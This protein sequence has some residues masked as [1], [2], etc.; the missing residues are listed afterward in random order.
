M[1]GLSTTDIGLDT[2]SLLPAVLAYSVHPDNGAPVSIAIE[3]HYSD[4]RTVS[5]VQIPF[6]IQR[7]VNGFLQLDI[8]VS[9]AAVN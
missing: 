8:L 6:H 7:Y 4:Y 2:V 5:G 9:S 1:T 3:I